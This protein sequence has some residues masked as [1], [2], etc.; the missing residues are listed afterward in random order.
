[1]SVRTRGAS[2]FLAFS[3]ATK[4]ELLTTSV[5]GTLLVRVADSTVKASAPTPDV[6]RQWR[7]GPHE[8]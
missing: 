5:N 8:K 6:D 1:M 2:G 7:V 4:F 3:A